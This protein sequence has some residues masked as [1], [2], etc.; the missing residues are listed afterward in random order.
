M[1]EDVEQCGHPTKD[2]DGSPCQ[3]SASYDDGRCYH[4]TDTADVDSG[5]RPFALG[6]SDH[7]DILEAARMGASKAGCARAAGV[8]PNVLNRYLE[9][10]EHENFRQAFMRA[11]SNGEMK[12]LEG[13]L[14]ERKNDPEP[15]KQMDG[16]H[17]R[18]ILSTSFDYKKTEKKEIA[19]EGGGPLEFTIEREVVD[20]N[21]N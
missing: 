19:G 20:G 2:G 6:E 10:E 11:R 13:A 21:D 3:L 9:A 14:Y 8:Q 15:H 4:H 18:F 17:A 16:Q 1:T 12:L 5:G 7:E